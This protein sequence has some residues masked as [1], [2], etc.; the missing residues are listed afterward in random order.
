[1]QLPI[2]LVALIVALAAVVGAV[3]GKPPVPR[4]QSLALLLPLAVAA[5]LAIRGAAAPWWLGPVAALALG[6]VVY[7]GVP[8]F[9]PV[10]YLAVAVGAAVLGL[11]VGWP[12]AASGRAAALAGAAV[13]V[14]IASTLIT[15]WTSRRGGAWACQTDRLI[16]GLAAF[17]GAAL[18]ILGAK[19]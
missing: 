18:L 11:V 4:W 17:A 10:R 9:G 13:A 2:G 14:L 16:G 3:A 8:L 5:I 1:M 19:A 7:A 12:Q 6:V 15:S